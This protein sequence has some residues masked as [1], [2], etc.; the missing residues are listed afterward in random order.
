[1]IPPCCSLAQGPAAAAGAPSAR[2]G[3]AMIP[4]CCALFTQGTRGG[5]AAGAPPARPGGRPWQPWRPPPPPGAPTNPCPCAPPPACRRACQHGPRTR[6]RAPDQARAA[7]RRRTLETVMLQ[8]R[9]CVLPSR[10]APACRQ[11][12]NARLTSAE[13]SAQASSSSAACR[14]SARPAAAAPWPPPRAARRAEQPGG[15]SRG[16]GCSPR[17]PAPWPL[18]H[19]ARAGVQPARD[20]SWT[21]AVR[22]AA[23]PAAPACP[24]S[25]MGCAVAPVASSA[26]VIGAAGSRTDGLRLR[27]R[28]AVSDGARAFLLCVSRPAVLAAGGACSAA[29]DSAFA[30]ALAPAPAEATG[31]EA[32][33]ACAASFA[34]APALPLCSNVQTAATTLHAAVSSLPSGGVVRT[35]GGALHVP[36]PAASLCGGVRASG[37]PLR[38][39]LA[40]GPWAAPR[41]GGVGQGAGAPTA[42][43][44]HTPGS[45]TRSPMGAASGLP[46]PSPCRAFA[47]GASARAHCSS[48]LSPLAAATAPRLPAGASAAPCRTAGGARQHRARPVACT[49]TSL[50]HCIK[51]Q[52]LP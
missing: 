15:L 12:G 42:R 16:L 1:M 40:P 39:A 18:P 51:P 29:D 27:M 17:A 22:P 44:A 7:S 26:G 6:A 48:S 36:R 35:V 11:G 50:S 9:R 32:T 23:P 28:P 52:Q 47:A 14:P 24:S 4:R 46:E 21:G 31:G 37:A 5:W 13:T 33:L 3:N 25:I 38:G 49:R 30:G 34:P 41:P 8:D 19:A 2:P 43:G 10:P 20:I 45:D